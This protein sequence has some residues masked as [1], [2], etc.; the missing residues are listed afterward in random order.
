M[1]SFR[2]SP[3][4]YRRI[5]AF[6]LFA[7]CA[8]VVTGAAV[9]LTGS[10]LGCTTWPNC[11]PGSL[12]PRQ[13]SGVAGW[14]EFLNRLFTGVLGV[15]VIVA[16]L[17]SR[18]RTTVRRDLVLWSY[19]L[20]A[21]VF[22]NALLG[23]L[24]VL[25]HLSPKLV[26]G[27]YLLSAVTIFCGAVLLRRAGEPDG[28]VRRLQVTPALRALAIGIV[29][30]AGAVL[31]SGT[32]VT[33]AGPHAGDVVAARLDVAITSVARIHS[34]FVWALVATTVIAW[35][36]VRR[37]DGV[38]EV[39]RALRLLLA[40]EIAQGAIG[41]T[42]YALGVPEELVAAHVLGSVIVWFAAV[43]VLLTTTTAV[44]P[45]PSPDVATAAAATR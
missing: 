6:A 11:E 36:R 18:R 19:S 14:I 45:T 33:G 13:E 43:R 5:T 21:G 37:G 41:Y 20:V 24:V 23:G 12:V 42:Q 16:V 29:V 32:V 2:V 15:T 17:A 26:A 34:V 30:L 38:P 10:G 35:I 44:V 8:I 28:G 1:R 9:R 7:L 40:V 27:H 31:V 3:A 4:S 22:A 25:F 39:D